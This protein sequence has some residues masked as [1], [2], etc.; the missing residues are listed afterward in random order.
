MFLQ[1]QQAGSVAS[2]HLKTTEWVLVVLSQTDFGWWGVG[3]CRRVR[4]RVAGRDWVD[5]VS[6]QFKCLCPYSA[7]SLYPH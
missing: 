6:L 4:V 5:Q 3:G 1:C 2:S 7:Y